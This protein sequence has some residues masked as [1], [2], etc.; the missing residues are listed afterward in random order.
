M[1]NP[2]TDMVFKTIYIYFVFLSMRKSCDTR[3]LLLNDLTCKYHEKVKIQFF[4]PLRLA[5]VKFAPRM[6]AII[7]QIKRPLRGFTT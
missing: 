7:S 6:W 3:R 2:T 1:L 4:P 5:L